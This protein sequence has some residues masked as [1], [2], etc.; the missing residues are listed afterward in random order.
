M[1]L[2]MVRVVLHRLLLELDCM[3]IP[4]QD[5]QLIL[6]DVQTNTYIC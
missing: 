1:C 5:P 4:L 6:L 2:A 3:S